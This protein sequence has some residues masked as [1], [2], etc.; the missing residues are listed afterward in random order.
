MSVGTLEKSIRGVTLV[1]LVVAIVVLSVA[2]VGLMAAYS[3]VV[4]S[5]ADPMIYQQ[6]LAIADSMMEEIMS[7][8]YPDSFSGTCASG[9][10]DRTL[11]D[12]VCDYNGYSS[13]TITD[14]AGNDLN[15]SGYSVQ[16]TVAGAG[17]DLGLATDDAVR[18]DVTVDNPLASAV[19]LTSYRA[20]Y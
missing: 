15:I 6:A 13:S 9:G 16:V 19:V 12:D 17:D 10:S 18:I 11:F 2:M 4:G 5:S 1:E 20:K 7:K 3:R 8:G 14:V